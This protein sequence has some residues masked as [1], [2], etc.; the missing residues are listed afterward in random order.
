MPH[1]PGV[2]VLEVLGQGRGRGAG[3]E[4]IPSEADFSFHKKNMLIITCDDAHLD[5][6]TKAITQA[7]HTGNKG[8]GLLTIKEVTRVIRLRTGETSSTAL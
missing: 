3:G 5:L 6:I 8:D 1:F 7:A 2:S 4:F